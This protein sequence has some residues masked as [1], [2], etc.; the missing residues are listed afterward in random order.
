MQDRLLLHTHPVVIGF[1]GDAGICINRYPTWAHGTGYVLTADLA[2]AIAAGTAFVLRPH[3]LFKLEDVSMGSWV[4]AV[5]KEHQ[6]SV[7]IVH[8]GRFNFWGCS[9]NDVVSHYISPVKQRCMHQRHG[10][11]CNRPHV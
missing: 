9:P 5:A 4:E 1:V 6:L 8:S 11:C 3:R 10:R 2:R 7:T